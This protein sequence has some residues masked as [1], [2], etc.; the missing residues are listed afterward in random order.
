MSELAHRLCQRFYGSA[1]HPYRI[2]EDEVRGFLPA[3]GFLLDAGCGRTAPVLQ[4]FRGLAGRMVGVDRVQFVSNATDI[5]LY[6]TD[7]E[8]IPVESGTVDVVMSRSVFEHLEH[9]EPVYAEIFRVLKPG[10][11]LVFLTANIWDYATMIARIVPNRLHPKI[12]AKT[13]GRAE[14]DV[15]PTCYKTNSRGAVRKLAD[16]TGFA[17]ESF[18]YLGQY[19]NYFLFNAPLFVLG[20]MYDKVVSRFTALEILRGWILVTLVK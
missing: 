13:E 8:S 14:E 7:L 4:K 19:P 5:E 10:G 12:V 17:I 15:F 3:G 16:S 18:R 2:F 9:P 20:T 1:H 11:R 6:E